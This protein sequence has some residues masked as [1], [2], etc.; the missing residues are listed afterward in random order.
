M[1][2][3][4]VLLLDET[5]ALNS[6]HID[7]S[8]LDWLVSTRQLLPVTIRGKRRYFYKDLENLVQVYRTVQNR[9]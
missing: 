4:T 8:D 7:Q 1:T 9:A 2:I 5:D 3:P 6:L